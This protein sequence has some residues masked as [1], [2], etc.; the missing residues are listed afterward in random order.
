MSNIIT[1]NN[2][3]KIIFISGT[4]T[5]RIVYEK[6]KPELYEKNGYVVE[7]WDLSR[8]Y[9]SEIALEA[10]FRGNK[11]YKPEF[12]SESIFYSRSEVDKALSVVQQ[13]TMFCFIDFDQH[14]DYWLRRLFKQY[15]VKY[16]IGPK[17]TSVHFP[18]KKK[19]VLSINV[20]P[21]KI[22][23]ALLA[24]L[25]F[26]YFKRKFHDI[27]YRYTNYYERPVFVIGSGLLGRYEWINRTQSKCFVSVPSVDIEQEVSAN[28]VDGPFCVYVDDAVAY[29]PDQSMMKV[30]NATC[31]DLEQYSINIC[32]VFEMV[33]KILRCKVVIA[34]SGKLQ[35]SDN[36][37]FGDRKIFYANTNQLIQHAQ[38]VIGHASSASWQVVASMKPILLLLDPTFIQAKN[39]GI[40]EMASF[41]RITPILSTQLTSSHIVN[42]LAVN[43]EYF[44]MLYEQYFCEK[45]VVGS[46]ESLIINA[47][48]NYSSIDAI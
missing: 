33:E 16:Y 27:I 48:E 4:P 22:K 10:Y 24:R 38:F 15:N 42:A 29:S 30:V 35:Y 18:W 8:L 39:I 41:L 46:A 43:N 21:H 7:Y 37:I 44:N 23:V 19:E 14:L 32:K 6:L 20:L 28:I 3:H 12:P 47:L 13:D 36:K 1:I 11:Q 31:L 25:K 9:Y 5:S 17:R 40:N 34:T 2:I 26:S 45:N